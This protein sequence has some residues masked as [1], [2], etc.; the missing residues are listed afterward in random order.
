[1]T[2]T[3]VPWSSVP[4]SARPGATPKRAV[5]LLH[6]PFDRAPRQLQVSLTAPE[7]MRP[8]QPLK[9]KVQAQNADGSIPQKVNVLVAAVDVGILNIT[10]YADA[11]S[12]RRACSAARPTALTSS[13]STAS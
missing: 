5:G 12:V 6:L 2:C 8:Q 1:M 9:V 13:M 3:S 7:K 10:G 11:R 4:A